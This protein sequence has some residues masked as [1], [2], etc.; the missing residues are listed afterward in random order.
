MEEIFGSRL[1]EIALK[2]NLSLQ[3]NQVLKTNKLQL[4]MSNA[5]LAADGTAGGGGASDLGF[6]YEDD[7]GDAVVDLDEAMPDGADESDDED[8][9]CKAPASGPGDGSDAGAQGAMVSDLLGTAA[10]LG[11]P[12]GSTGS[13]RRRRRK[14]RNPDV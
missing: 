1:M 3:S 10:S 6:G 14:H 9:A 12:E 13:G 8:K 4:L 2:A 7:R 5:A 11:A